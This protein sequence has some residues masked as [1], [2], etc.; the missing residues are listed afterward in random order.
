MKKIV[1]YS[2]EQW[3]I[4][5]IALYT[6]HTPDEFQFHMHARKIIGKMNGTRLPH[7]CIWNSDKF[8]HNKSLDSNTTNEVGSHHFTMD[9]SHVL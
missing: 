2:L 4:L 1:L 8:L 3:Y 7:S 6:V 9:T 5:Y